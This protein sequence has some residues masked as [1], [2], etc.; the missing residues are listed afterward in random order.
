[1]LVV[2]ITV[3]STGGR[4]FLVQKPS[5]L[6]LRRSWNLGKDV[7]LPHFETSTIPHCILNL[8]SIFSDSLTTTPHQRSRSL[9]QMEIITVNKTT[10]NTE[11]N[12]S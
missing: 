5:V 8:I 12:R 1:M 6:G 3:Y 7:Q 10:H 9:Q 2:S 4:P 11:I